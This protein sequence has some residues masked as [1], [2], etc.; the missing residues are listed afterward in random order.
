MARI[1]TIKPEFWTD[2]KI[3]ECSTNAR[4]LFVGTWTFADDAGNIER[5]AKQLKAQVFPYDSIDCEPL[6]RELIAAG[7]L[8]EYQVEAKIYLHING[9]GVHQKIDRPGK[10]RCPA[11]DQSL[12]IRR[13]FDEYSS[14][15]RR[16]LAPESKGR[17]SKGRESLGSEDRTLS[18]ELDR[19]GDCETVFAHWQ[20]E[21]GHA[22]AKLDPK[23]RKL[24]RN[25]LAT[26]DADTLC[27]AISGYKLSPHHMGQNDRH[28]VYDDIE[29][30]LRDS[31]HIEAGLGF[32][33]AVEPAKSQVEILQQ[34]IREKLN[35]S[36][37]TDDRVVSEQDGTGAASVAT[38]SRLLR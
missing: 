2:E 35:G 25:A 28:T 15:S 36:K 33:R 1:R 4:L 7:L 3:G 5:S 16:A 30:M 34:Q 6:L 29:L 37:H 27:Q 19:P 11:F 8:I 12:S 24:I 9:F 18:S 10:P 21:H 13:T 23:R 31:K 26:Y 22:Q 38:V 14:K 17:E 20:R 32:A